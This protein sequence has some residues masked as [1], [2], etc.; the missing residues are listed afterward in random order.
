[1]KLFTRVKLD[2]RLRVIAYLRTGNNL[3]GDY[4]FLPENHYGN[5]GRIIETTHLPD[6]YAIVEVFSEKRWKQIWRV[7]QNIC[8]CSAVREARRNNR[9]WF[10]SQIYQEATK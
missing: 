5:I 8:A 6:S 3:S 2:R 4:I 1:M 10:K 9:E 7:L